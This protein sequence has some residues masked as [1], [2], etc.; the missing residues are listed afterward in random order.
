MTVVKSRVKLNNIGL[1]LFL[2]LFVVYLMTA[3][4]RIDSGDGRIVFTVSQ[5][6]LENLD[7]SVPPPDPDLVAFDAQ[8]RPLGKA[9][10]LGIEDSNNIV[11]RRGNFYSPTGIGHSLLILPLLALGR[12]LAA[13]ALPGSS[14]WM[15][16][17]VA[18]MLFNPLVTAVSGL[19][20]YLIGRRL[21]WGTA[22]C[23]AMAVIYA[24]GTMTWV[25][26]KSFFSDPLI[27]L[28]LLLAFYGL[29]S[30]RF[31]QQ[32]HWL[33]LAGASLGFAALTKP[34][35][36]ISAPVFVVYLAFVVRRDALPTVLKR[37]GAFLVPVMISVMLIMA[38]NW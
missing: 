32:Q 31:T 37:L 12:A 28:F 6:L 11:G 4:G 7:V 5:S 26:A 13:S 20:V 2:V 29:L 27:A 1:Q 9:A 21:L 18:S 10:E 16:E 24:F 14:Q 35:S 22:T 38:Y 34:A 15:M 3:S 8:G 17:F 25:Y 19:L 36:L 30:F 23:V 33:W